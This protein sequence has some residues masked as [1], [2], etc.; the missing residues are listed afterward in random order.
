MNPCPPVLDS[1]TA[2]PKPPVIPQRRSRRMARAIVFLVLLVLVLLPQRHGIRELILHPPT[3]QE[4]A[5]V[6][7]NAPPEDL[8]LIG[9][10]VLF[11]AMGYVWLVRLLFPNWRRTKERL[12]NAAMAMWGGDDC[13]GPGG[14]AKEWKDFVLIFVLPLLF[15][16]AG[17]G[18]YYG[19]KYLLFGQMPP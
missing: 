5:E 10:L 7:G 1:R 3:P 13:D 19:L 6:T 4:W 2:G 16:G 9:G 17:L 11:N 8:W 14:G 18:E 15:Y 12:A